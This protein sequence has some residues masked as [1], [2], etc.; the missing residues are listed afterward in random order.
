MI[1]TSSLLYSLNIFVP[2]PQFIYF[3]PQPQFIYWNPNP[4]GDGIQSWGRWEVIKSSKRSALMKETPKS[5]LTP[6]TVWGHRVNM[7]ICKLEEGLHQ[8]PTMLAP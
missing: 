5:S 7:S 4:K 8:D 3:V 6:S 2:Q 1:S